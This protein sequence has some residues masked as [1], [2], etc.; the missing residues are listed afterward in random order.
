M[1]LEVDDVDAAV[2][3][4]LAKGVR[5]VDQVP[6]KGAHGNRIA[7]IHPSE[8]GGVLVEICQHQAG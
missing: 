3:E 5:M 4:L 2:Q 8:T 1:A 6:R 7:F